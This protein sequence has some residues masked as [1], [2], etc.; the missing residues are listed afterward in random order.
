MFNGDDR[1]RFKVFRSRFKLAKSGVFQKNLFLLRTPHTL[2][3]PILPFLSPQFFE[4]PA[5]PQLVGET[6]IVKLLGF[7]RG[8]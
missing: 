2:P 6:R 3:L 1:M 7:R 4:K 8:P 5:V